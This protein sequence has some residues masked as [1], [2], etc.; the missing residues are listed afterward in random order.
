LFVAEGN[1]L[2][3][4]ILPFFDC[5]LLIAKPSWISS[6]GNFAVRELITADDND[7]SRASLLKN[8]QDVIA[9]FIQPN[10][11]LNKKILKNELTLVLDG[12][13]DPGNLGTIVRVAN[14]FGIR[15]MI[16]SPDT[17]DIYNPKTVQASMGS[18]AQ[19]DVFYESLPE[20]FDELKGIHIYGTF[21]DGEVLYKEKL[22][23]SGFIV[24]GNEGNGIRPEI[25][26]RINRRLYVPNFPQGSDST[27]SLNVAVATAIVCG[28]FRRQQVYLG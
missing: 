2:V 16:C 19:V 26:Q 25:E 11:S 18:I 4:E 1:K 5:E 27:D 24:M 10:R 15:N 3:A 14:W 7:I 17:A 9:V 6:Q 21:L 13:Q 20:L 28:E 12:I 22:Q 23:S 8:P